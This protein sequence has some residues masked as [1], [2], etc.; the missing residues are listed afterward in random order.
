M[1]DR[2][3]A[4]GFQVKREKIAFKWEMKC[5]LPLLPISLSLVFLATWRYLF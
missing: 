5:P 4:K 3:A 1:L 2:Q